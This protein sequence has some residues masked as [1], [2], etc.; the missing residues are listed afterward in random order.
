MMPGEA[1]LKAV[2]A[3][4]QV[5]LALS[6]PELI[7]RVAVIGRLTGRAVQHLDKGMVPLGIVTQE[8]TGD[9]GV[10][11]L[12][13][14]IHKLVVPTLK[15]GWLLAAA[16]VGRRPKRR[17]EKSDHLVISMPNTAAKSGA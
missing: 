16:M 12:A 13:R 9:D 11:V 15:E 6:C 2:G 7:R 3:N 1:I 8:D 10:G 4:T 5:Q 17:T 14:S